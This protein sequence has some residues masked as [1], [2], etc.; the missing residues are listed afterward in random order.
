MRTCR[1]AGLW[2][3]RNFIADKR[4]VVPIEDKTIVFHRM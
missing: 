4:Q 3:P 2:M 1:V